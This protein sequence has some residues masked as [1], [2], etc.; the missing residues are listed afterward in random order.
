MKTIKE[1]KEKIEIVGNSFKK[2]NLRV[3]DTGICNLDKKGDCFSII[4]ELESIDDNK[5]D[6]FI[7]LKVN[8]YDSEGIIYNTSD[9]VGG[10]SGYDTIKISLHDEKLVLNAEKIKLFASKM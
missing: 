5:V 10:F 3:I 7:N 8:V 6:D 1:L 9:M 2:L 4:I